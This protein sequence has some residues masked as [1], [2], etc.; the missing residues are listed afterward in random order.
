MSKSQPPSVSDAP[1]LENDCPLSAAEQGRNIF[2]YAA[3]W[4]L[5]YLA[6][7]VT[8]VGLTHANLLK[9]LGNSDTVANL[10]HAVYQWLTAV[11][12]LVAWFFPQ[13][14]MLKP[15]LVVP[16][17]V[18]ASMSGAVALTIWAGMSPRVVSIVVIVHGAVFGAS[19]G[20]L[21]TT[22]WEVLRRGVS[23]SRRGSA[24][25]VTFGVGPLLACV[26]SL[27]QQALF[28]KT[29]I[30]GLSLGLSFPNNYLALFAAAV[31]VQLLETLIAASF[32]IPLPTEEPAS[33]SRVAE[34]LGGLRRF[35]TYRPLVM[36]AVAYLL[37]YSGGNAI[38][39]NVSLHAK[40]VLKEAS[41]TTMGTQSFLRFGFKAA[42]GICFGWLLTK[43]SAK[44]MLLTTTS[45]LIFGMGWAL[46]VTGWWYLIAMGWLGAG[47]LFGVYFP[48]Y[49][50]T[51]SSKSQVRVNMALLNLLSALVGFASVIFGQISDTFGR[52]ASFY[53]ALRFLA[54]GLV[55]IVFALPA[56][57]TPRESE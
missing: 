56:R 10:P 30:G 1:Q 46:N 17:L 33:E 24:L 49:I 36:G 54:A 3:F 55:L 14:K 6:A 5:H 53:V 52:I 50:T 25:G 18:M 11:P 22:L 19:G 21:L 13:P 20:V 16:L 29:P 35:F 34:I 43:S 26:G 41:A 47:E 2:C 32:L 27:A 28:S 7:P 38:I 37:V 9:E 23:T 44:V 12:I 40:D 15:L 42:A 4:C 48:N 39:D 45:V 8:Y 57:P 31:P 51:S